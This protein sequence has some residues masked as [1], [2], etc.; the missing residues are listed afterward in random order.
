[1]GANGMSALQD[2]QQKRSAIFKSMLEITTILPAPMQADN[3]NQ[4]INGYLAVIES[5]LQ[6]DLGPRDEYLGLVIPPLK[7]GQM[8][9][10]Y[11]IGVLVGVN[12]ALVAVIDHAHA[13]WYASF[14]STY[15]D[16]LCQLWE[17]S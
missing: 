2:F 17:N 14:L 9:L 7:Q 4:F 1:M 11:I 6:G 8:P 10:G 12:T 5:A 16:K 15:A 3:A 13:P